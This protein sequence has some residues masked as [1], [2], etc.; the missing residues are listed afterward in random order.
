MRRGQKPVVTQLQ[1]STADQAKSQ[2]S[3]CSRRRYWNLPLK[4][5]NSAEPTLSVPPYSVP[6]PQA[7]GAEHP[8]EDETVARATTARLANGLDPMHWLRLSVR[9][10]AGPLREQP[11][12]AAL[13]EVATRGLLSF[14]TWQ[15]NRAHISLK[16]TIDVPL[17]GTVIEQYGDRLLDDSLMPVGWPLHLDGAVKQWSVHRTAT[18]QELTGLLKTYD[19]KRDLIELNHKAAQC[20]GNRRHMKSKVHGN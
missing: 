9:E 8:F 19:M 18:F 3:L 13:E 14:E 4:F 7:A 5:W 20:T 11:T 1:E 10:E 15:R 17:L 6:L 16:A 2:V 12:F